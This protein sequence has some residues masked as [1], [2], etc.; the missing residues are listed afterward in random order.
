LPWT[1]I[2][3][4]ERSPGCQS[5]DRRT[6]SGSSCAWWSPFAG[7]TPEEL[8]EES[9]PSAQAIRNW[10]EQADLDQGVRSGG[11]TTDERGELQRLR[12]E[13]KQLKREREI[14][15]SEPR[16]G[17]L[18]RAGRSQ[19]GIRVREGEPGES[20]GAADGSHAR[21]LAEWLIRMERATA[22][23]PYAYERGALDH[24][25]DLCRY[26]AIV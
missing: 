2:L 23:G 15:N 5:P 6:R 8:A 3:Y 1:P 12:R 10:A 13:N 26:Q 19:I 20:P 25:R 22:G 9:E 21:S 4:G 11:L 16:L 17:S 24:A 18:G 7:R 14:P